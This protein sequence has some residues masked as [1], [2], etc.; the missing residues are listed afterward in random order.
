MSV[1][2]GPVVQP[3]NATG[4]VQCPSCYAVWAFSQPTDP[5]YATQ[6]INGCCGNC[7]RVVPGLPASV[8][9]LAR[10]SDISGQPSD[11]D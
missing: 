7:G 1:H 9:T 6:D 11:R 10:A 3:S 5:N 2:E 4:T 8:V